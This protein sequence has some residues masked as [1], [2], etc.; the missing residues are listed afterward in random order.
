MFEAES[1]FFFFSLRKNGRTRKI[2][3]VVLNNNLSRG[4]CS[5]QTRNYLV[6]RRTLF[7]ER[8]NI[9]IRK[10]G[11]E[12][13]GLRWCSR[14]QP[15]RIHRSCR[16]P[17]GHIKT[18]EVRV[19]EIMRLRSSLSV[20]ALNSRDRY[21]IIPCRFPLRREISSSESCIINL[22]KHN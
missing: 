17:P 15:L 2:W 20:C 4:T 18:S 6:E 22:V 7:S 21:G 19:R 8:S 3:R 12:L 5:S 1:K 9:F 14:L 13:R 16:L 11:R 10:V